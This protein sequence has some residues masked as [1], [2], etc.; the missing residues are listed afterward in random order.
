[1]SEIP[2]YR[3]RETKGG[4]AQFVLI[5]ADGQIAATSKEYDSPRAAEQAVQEAKRASV[6]IEAKPLRV[7]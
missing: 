6:R 4:K 7:D 5:G 3:I 2:H 1:M